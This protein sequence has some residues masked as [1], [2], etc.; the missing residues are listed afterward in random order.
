MQMTMQCMQQIDLQHQNTIASIKKFEI[1]ISQLS[2]LLFEQ[3][4]ETP[5]NM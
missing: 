4:V 5:P 2:Y 1:Q 3:I